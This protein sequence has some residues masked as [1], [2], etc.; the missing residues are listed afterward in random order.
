MRFQRVALAVT[1]ALGLTLMSA[2]SSAAAP[3]GAYTTKGAWSFASAPGVHPPMLRTSGRTASRSLARGDFL[4]ANFPILT[5]SGPMTGQGG[6]LIVD[7]GLQ[8]VWFRSVGTSVVSGDLQQETFAGKPV[9][10]WWQ[11]VLTHAGATS[12]GEVQI[13]DQHYRKVATLKA[14]GPTGCRGAAC[15]QISIHDAVISGNDIWVTVY[16]NVP[17]QNLTRY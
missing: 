10:A 4:L 15:W 11:G 14:Q 8:P 7:R 2:A 13:V 16:R 1:A 17:G 6:P 12:S 9:L 3:I 5:T